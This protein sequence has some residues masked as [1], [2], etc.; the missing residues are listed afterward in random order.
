M[1]IDVFLTKS[2]EKPEIENDRRAQASI[3]SIS[4]FR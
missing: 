1:L 3:S 4:G 2:R